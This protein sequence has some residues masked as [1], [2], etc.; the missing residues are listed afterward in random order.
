MAWDQ[1]WE[2]IFLEHEWG[3][4]PSENLIQ[5]VAKNYYG[6]NRGAINILEIGCGPGAN[7]WYLA[8]ESFN[9]S[10][11][12][13]SKTAIIRARNRL[14]EEGLSAKLIVGDIISLPYVDNQFDA[15]IDN[16]CIYCNSKIESIKIIV[17]AKRVMKKGGL[18]YS[19][20]FAENMYTGKHKKLHENL[21]FSDISDGPFQNRGFVRLIDRKGIEDLYGKFYDILSIDKIE[22]T[23]NNM[24]ALISEWVI[25]C[26]KNIVEITYDESKL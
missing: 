21:E 24:K 19:R 26:R 18:L 3:K 16:E 23:Y 20:T 12:D 9:V 17:E 6:R 25:V 14:N 10:G 4:Y 15:V 11:I 5:F 22:Y 13:G 1:I 7:I 8:R 2:K